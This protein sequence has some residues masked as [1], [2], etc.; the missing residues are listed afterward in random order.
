MSEI[1][2]EAFAV[3]V[4]DVLPAILLIVD[5]DVRLKYANSFG[6][7][8]VGKHYSE[9]LNGRVGDLLHCVHSNEGP[10]GCG[11][12]A[13]C[14]NCRLRSNVKS[15]IIEKKRIREEG[16][17]LT[18]EGIRYAIMINASLITVEKEEA[19][20]LY[21]EDLREIS[22]LRDLIPICMKCHK[23][24][25][26]DSYWQSVE[27]YLQEHTGGDVTHGLCDDCLERHFPQPGIS[28]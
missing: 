20:M 8:L 17:I 6:E 21:L 12:G 1:Y 16:E 24:R 28:R 9:A 25:N 14:N 7:S 13:S 2:K 22:Q 5:I 15:V 10:S 18:R 3:Q 26:S 4:L 19:V 23:I 11:S 27:A